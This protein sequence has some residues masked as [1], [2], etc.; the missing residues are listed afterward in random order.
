MAFPT[1]G[2]LR[3]FA[4][5]KVNLFLH[6]TGRLANGYHTLDSLVA[7]SRDIGDVVSI[8]PA[9]RFRFSVDGP[10][11]PLFS[12]EDRDGG[13]S[14]SNLCVRAALA[15][16]DA[17]DLAPDVHIHLTK[18][19]P[20]AAG[21]G[22]GSADAAA[23]VRGLLSLWGV[24]E[25]FE[26]LAN[27]LKD[28]GAD[29]PACYFGEPVQLQGIGDVLTPAPALPKMPVVLVNPLIPCP[30]PQVFSTWHATQPTP[31]MPQTLPAMLADRDE[32]IAYLLAQRNDLT[33]AARQVVP[34]IS[35]VL[36]AL[37]AQPGC[38]LARLSGSGA[39]CFGLF[40][41]R[42]QAISAAESLQALK[43]EW[44]SASGTF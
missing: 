14:S 32:F 18:N 42:D 37:L 26:G 39:S 34:S 13:L 33:G 2:A 6:V 35:E 28:L 16:A 11:A 17:T 20:Q 8:T 27:L 43:P 7:F 24:P 41:Q 5:A 22:G 38:L 3:V 21:L 23:V 31:S 4:P 36:N 44:W 40:E 1:S 12:D 19:L 9:E 25:R 29:V 30:T 15:L 10:F